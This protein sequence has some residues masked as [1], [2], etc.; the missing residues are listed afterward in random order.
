MKIK[1]ERRR[2]VPYAQRIFVGSGS[3]LGSVED[4][5]RIRTT[6]TLSLIFL[7]LKHQS[8]YRFQVL[9]EQPIPS[10]IAPTLLHFSILCN[11]KTYTSSLCFS[12]LSLSLPLQLT[13]QLKTKTPLSEKSS[14]RT[15]ESW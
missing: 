4:F 1:K 8:I 12:S 3:E 7:S 5:V 10:L 15:G 2:W 11:F 13:W 14:P 6:Q 9:Q